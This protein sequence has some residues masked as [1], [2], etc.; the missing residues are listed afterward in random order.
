MLVFKGESVKKRALALWCKLVGVGFCA[1]KDVEEGGVVVTKGVD[2][3]CFV[4]RAD[5]FDVRSFVE[6]GFG[7]VEVVVFDGEPE[8]VLDVI[9][10]WEEGFEGGVEIVFES[11]LNGAL[12]SAV[13][14]FRIRSFFDEGGDDL[15]CLFQRE[16][17]VFV[18]LEDHGEGWLVVDEGG[19]A[20]A[21]F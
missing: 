14:L 8:G 6:E 18:L 3:G 20:G 7:C 11:D 13:G 1:Q 9:D 12:S 5:F 16:V 2:E 19:G 21:F 17:P 4:M 10:F 15:V